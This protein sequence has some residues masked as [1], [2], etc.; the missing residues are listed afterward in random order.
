MTSR[1]WLDPKAMNLPM[2]FTLP[3]ALEEAA[4]CSFV[5]RADISRFVFV[6]LAYFFFFSYLVFLVFG[7]FSVH[8]CNVVQFYFVFFYFNF[9]FLFPLGSFLRSFFLS[10]CSSFPDFFLGTFYFSIVLYLLI[11]RFCLFSPIFFFIISHYF[12]IS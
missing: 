10:V 8:S 1:F 12:I 2:T 6:L 7:S 11:F 5:A 9:L 4:R 3:A